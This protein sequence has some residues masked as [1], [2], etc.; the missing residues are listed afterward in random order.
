MKRYRNKG[1]TFISSGTDRSCNVSL[2]AHS[3]LSVILINNHYVQHLKYFHL[4]SPNIILCMYLKGFIWR[5]ACLHLSF[6]T[7]SASTVWSD[8]CSFIGKIGTGKKGK[9]K[10]K[11]KRKER[12]LEKRRETFN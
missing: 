11:R 8:M 3:L 7:D 2:P 6:I 5:L 4:E 12:T 9:E 10:A 1:P